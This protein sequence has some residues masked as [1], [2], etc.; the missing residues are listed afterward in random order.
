MFRINDEKMTLS[1]YPRGYP[2]S[3]R[4]PTAWETSLLVLLCSFA[5]QGEEYA[6]QLDNCLVREVDD[7]EQ[8]EIEI[9]AEAAAVN[10]QSRGGM[11]AEASYTDD[12]GLPVSFL[13]HTDHGK[14]EFLEKLKLNP[15]HPVIR[16]TP[17]LDKLR[18]EEPL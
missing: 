1:G 11:I 13:L 17:A 8:L 3:W 9:A 10:T 7:E 12:D 16:K 18:R 14:L 5:E 15:E 4:R 2:K 6:R